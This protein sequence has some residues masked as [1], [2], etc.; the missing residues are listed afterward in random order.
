MHGQTTI[1]ILGILYGVT[2]SSGLVHKTSQE[3]AK[4][5]TDKIIT[6]CVLFLITFYDS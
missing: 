6:P 1:K 4:V 5:Q 2:N 3:E